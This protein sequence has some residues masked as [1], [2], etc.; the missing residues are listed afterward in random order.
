[1]IEKKKLKPPDVEFGELKKSYENTGSMDFDEGLTH[2]IIEGNKQRI[3]EGN[4]LDSS[5]NQGMFAFNADMM[6][7]HLVKNYD[8]AKKLYGETLL[9]LATG[10]DPGSLKRNLRFPEFQKQ[11]K[12]KLKQKEREMKDSDLLDNE[13]NISNKGL[14]LA[15]LVMYTKELDDLRAK[16]FGDRKS[17]HKM[18]YGDKN[19]IRN[20]KKHDRYRDIAIKSTVRSAIRHNHKTINESDFR[21]FERDSKGKICLVYAL[22]SSGS[23][24]GKKIEMCKKAGIA[25]AYKAINEKDNVGLIIFGSEVNDIVYPT[26]DFS[27]FLRKIT[28]IRAK[29]KTD[30]A[31]TIGKAI[32]MFPHDDVTKHLVLITDAIPTVGDN[33]NENTL[34][35]VEKARALGITISVVGIDLNSEGIELAKKISEIGSGNFYIISDLNNVDSIVLQDYYSL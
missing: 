23:M 25:L 14:E 12:N 30:I 19:N 21:V 18:V 16:D 29:K 15:A 27:Q 7:D 2:A 3:E 35:L 34:N 8:N 1:M 10:D 9:R 31:S 22:D 28:C 5:I 26:N 13:G 32:M 6:M 11:L 24:K 4:I 17:K 20:F 33:P